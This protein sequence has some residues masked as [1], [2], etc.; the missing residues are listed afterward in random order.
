MKND[1]FKPLETPRLLLRRFQDSDLP[2]ILAYRSDPEVA[3]YQGWEL[4]GEDSL[5]TLVTE[6]KTMPFGRPKLWFQLAIEHKASGRMIGDIG[7]KFNRETNQSEIGYTLARSYH[8]Q[9]LASEAVG[10][11]LDFL[12]D[13]V[14]LHRVIALV[15]CRNDRSIALLERLN[16]RCEG[17]FIHNAWSGTEWVDEYLYAMLQETWQ[18]QRISESANQRVSESANQPRESI[19]D[20]QSLPPAPPPPSS[21]APPPVPDPRPPT[22]KHGLVIVNTGS[23]KGK[24]TAALGMMARA[25]GH[26]MKVGIIQFIKHEKARFGEV[27]AGRRMGIDWIATGDGFTWTSR[28]MDET[29]ARARHGWQIAQE[30]IT[31]GGYDLLVLDEFTYPLHYG[32]LDTTAVI[33]W[34]KANKPPRLHLVITGRY[35]PPALIDYA[36]LVTEMAEVKHPYREQNIRAQAGVEF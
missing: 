11:V 28:D 22:P 14:G 31:A 18:N 29:E 20:R 6:M 35:A 25:W 33:D 12:F 24:T 19:S 17:H 15:D 30:R 8:R 13:E 16:F 21:P 32:W 10:R 9:G 2:A 23:G 27:I 4:A 26:N 7:L 34:L 36:D 3:R 1:R 5:R